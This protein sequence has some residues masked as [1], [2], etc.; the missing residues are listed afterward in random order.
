VRVVAWQQAPRCR[1]VGR[2]SVRA[3][4]GADVLRVPRR[5]GKHRVVAGTYRFL[6][7][8]HGIA[9]LDV[10]VRLVWR[11]KHLRVRRDNLADVCRATMLLANVEPTTGAVQPR[12][13]APRPAPARPSTQK[14]AVPFLPP[15]IRELSPANASPLVRA[16]FFALLA[17]AIATLAVSSL[18]DRAMTAVPGGSVVSGHRALTTLGGLA[19]FAAAVLVALLNS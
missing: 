10:R 12:R 9:V 19:L 8:S 15:R 2:Y 16:I 5:I 13:G 14:S 7:S 17:C 4:R 3:R 1:L 11:N 18:P 6:G